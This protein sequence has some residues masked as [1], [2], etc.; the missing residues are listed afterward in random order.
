MSA[1]YFKK[2]ANGVC[3]QG[4]VDVWRNCDTWKILEENNCDDFTKLYTRCNHL[5]RSKSSG[6]HTILNMV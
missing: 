5:S 3:S 1:A 4:Y 6:R 2:I